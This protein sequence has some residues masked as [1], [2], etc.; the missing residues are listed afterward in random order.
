MQRPFDE[1]IGIPH[2]RF[3]FVFDLQD[4]FA[5]F[6]GP[7]IN[8]DDKYLLIEFDSKYIRYDQVHRRFTS[9]VHRRF[10][11]TITN[12]FLPK[13]PLREYIVSFRSFMLAGELDAELEGQEENNQVKLGF[14]WTRPR[15]EFEIGDFDYD[16]PWEAINQN[17]EEYS[18][19]FAQDEGGGAPIEKSHEATEYWLRQE[20]FESQNFNPISK[21]RFALFNLGKHSRKITEPLKPG[22]RGTKRDI[23]PNAFHPTQQPNLQTMSKRN[24]AGPMNDEFGKKASNIDKKVAKGNVNI[25]NAEN[26][27]RHL[28]ANELEAGI[29]RL[30][31]EILNKI[32][33][34]PSGYDTPRHGPRKG[35]KKTKRRKSKGRRKTKRRKSRRRRK[36]KK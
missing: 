7:T 24:Y 18:K 16:I 28:P 12:P 22:S 19:F 8:R 17:L 31:P 32:A 29:G 15:Y 6:G 11:S 5:E 23:T 9:P 34:Y 25:Y 27:F 33:E 30:P 13:P 1:P 20:D 2:L 14:I 10:T 3:D 26:A 4:E 21:S 36:N 35:G